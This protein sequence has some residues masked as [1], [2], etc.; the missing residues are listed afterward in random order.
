MIHHIGIR[1]SSTK[2]FEIGGRAAARKELH[3]A[4]A[5]CYHRALRHKKQKQNERFCFCQLVDGR[6]GKTKSKNKKK[7]EKN[8]FVFV[9]PARTGLNDEKWAS[10]KTTHREKWAGAQR[11]N[12][13]SCV[14]VVGRYLDPI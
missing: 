8:V 12:D 2:K 10:A 1:H 6:T 5:F 11:K 7:E 14:V 3:F 13:T 4:F 9:V